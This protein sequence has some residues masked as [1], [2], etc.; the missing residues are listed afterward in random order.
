[1]RLDM[2]G[3]IEK[4]VDPT[5]LGKKASDVAKK[6]LEPDPWEKKQKQIKQ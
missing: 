4:K 2:S 5:Q 3:K 6:A 1:M